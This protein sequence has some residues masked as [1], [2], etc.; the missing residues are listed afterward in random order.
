M[1]RTAGL[2]ALLAAAAAAPA[3]A[4]EWAALPGATG[5]RTVLAYEDTQN[6]VR[7]APFELLRHPVTN[8]EFLAFVRSNPQWRRGGVPAVFAESRY[9]QHW[10]ADQEPGAAQS[11]QPV[12]QVSW[13]AAQAYCKALG[14]RLPSWLEWEYAAAADSTRADARQDPAWRERQLTWYAQPSTTPLAPV[15]SQPPDLHGVYDLHG[16]VWEWVDDAGALLISADNRDQGAA[17]RLQFC[18]AG[19]LS[20]ADR[21]NYAVLMRIALL[22]ALKASDTTANLGFRCARNLPPGEKKP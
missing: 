12:V 1:K 11:R 22:S 9:L 18:G 19:A 13:F 4:T 20:A 16:L 17:D 5:F 2:C 8:A 3:V 10:T 15:A 21:E 14:A 7:V 6:G